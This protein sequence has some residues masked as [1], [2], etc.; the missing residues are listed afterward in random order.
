M[1]NLKP[2]WAEAAG[3][4]AGEAERGG[5]PKERVTVRRPANFII[6]QRQ[7]VLAQRWA[8]ANQN[9]VRTQ[10]IGR[11]LDGALGVEGEEP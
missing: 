2:G 4:R 1:S 11:A 3:Q 9:G 6:A 8:R 7:A 10:R 5:G